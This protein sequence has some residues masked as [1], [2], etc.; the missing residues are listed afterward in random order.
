MGRLI[1]VKDS[2]NFN[3]DLGSVIPVAMEHEDGIL[4]A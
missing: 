2:T 4:K 3:P 1:V